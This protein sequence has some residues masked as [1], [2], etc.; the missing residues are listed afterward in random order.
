[1]PDYATANFKNNYGKL[2][3]LIDFDRICQRQVLSSNLK[4]QLVNIPGVKL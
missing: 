1:M 3:F 4:R 2:I